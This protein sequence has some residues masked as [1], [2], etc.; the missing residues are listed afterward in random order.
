MEQQLADS[1]PVMKNGSFF[2]EHSGFLI[3]NQEAPLDS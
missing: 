2:Q 1:F 3:W